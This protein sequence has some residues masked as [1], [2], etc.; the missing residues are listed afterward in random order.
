MSGTIDGKLGHHILLA[1]PYIIE[2][3]QLDELVDKLAG[4]IDRETAKVATEFANAS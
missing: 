2:S 1:P 3:A 4:A